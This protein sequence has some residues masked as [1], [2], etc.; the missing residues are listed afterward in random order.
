VTGL[1]IRVDADD[2]GAQTRALYRALRHDPDLAGGTRLSLQETGPPAADE[3]GPALDAVLAVVNGSAA[4]GALIVS[5]A[6]WREG[7]ALKWTV[8]FEK[9]G[10]HLQMEG[11]SEDE[12]RRIVRE[13]EEPRGD[14]S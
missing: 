6:S 8:S 10:L 4:L 14:D 13:L 3:L 1:L 5:I 9:D 12:L 2:T 11:G 7:R